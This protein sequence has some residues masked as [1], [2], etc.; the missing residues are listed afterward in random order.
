MHGTRDD[1]VPYQNV[2]YMCAHL[3][4]AK[5][6]VVKRLDGFNHFL[7]WNAKTHIEAAIAE[8]ADGF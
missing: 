4:G 1:L 6:V 3:T 8:L 2:D 5:H 7:P